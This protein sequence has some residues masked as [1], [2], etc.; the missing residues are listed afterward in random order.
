[1]A[2]R[3]DALIQSYPM[4]TWRVIAWP[5]I[6]LIAAFFLWAFFAELDEVTVAEGAVVPL[7]DLTVIQHL[8]GGRI[9]EINAQEGAHVHAGDTLLRLDVASAG[10]NQE[11]LQVQLDNQLAIQA[12]LDAEASGSSPEFPDDLRRR[13]PRF[14]SAQQ[15][16]YDAR[17]QE[18]DATL[19]VLDNQIRQRELEVRELSA[20]QKSAARN[21]NLAKERLKNSS[22]LLAQNL[23]PRN[24]HLQLEAEVEQLESEIQTLAAAIP[25]AA[26]GVEEARARLRETTDRFR[27]EARDELGEVEESI[28]RLAENLNV[29][30]EKSARLDIKTPV[31]GIVKN[32]RYTTIGGVVKPG[33]PI[34]EIVPTGSRLVVEARLNPVDR[35]FVAEGQ[36]ARVKIST[37]DFVRYGALDGTVSLVAPDVTNDPDKGPY[38]QVQIETERTYLGQSEGEL[39]ITPGMQATVDIHTGSRSVIDFLIKPVLKMKAEAFRER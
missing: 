1:M 23:V 34:L 18:L 6:T 2:D 27:R 10:L 36:P 28:A 38:F 9:L 3:L 19:N 21:L 39:P 7:G 20:K 31:D 17:K 33:E 22:E 15:R 24:E 29:A 35:G 12:R 11:E 8:E 14:V 30:G 26:A 4:P 32:M 37:Y 16:A 13:Q 5:I 25:R